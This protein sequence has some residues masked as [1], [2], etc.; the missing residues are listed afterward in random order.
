[1]KVRDQKQILLTR[2]LL[3]LLQ[4]LLPFGLYYVLGRGSLISA[5][6]ISILFLLVTLTMVVQK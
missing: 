1:M 2:A 5:W 3:L 4:I 6:V